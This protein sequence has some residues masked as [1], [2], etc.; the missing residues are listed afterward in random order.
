[1]RPMWPAAE[2]CQLS[3]RECGAPA[4]TQPALGRCGADGSPPT[5]Q[6]NRASGATPRAPR[7]TK[8]G[9]SALARRRGPAPARRCPGP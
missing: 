5:A 4:T 6:T 1:M 3:P 9:C 2:I 8:A 7:R